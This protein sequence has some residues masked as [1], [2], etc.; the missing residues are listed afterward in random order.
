MV[1]IKKKKSA[2]FFNYFNLNKVCYVKFKNCILG[3]ELLPVNVTCS[4]GQLL[5]AYRCIDLS[6]S[7][8]NYSGFFQ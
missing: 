6:W 7:Y 4:G 2:N 8:L 5:F 1:N 3:K